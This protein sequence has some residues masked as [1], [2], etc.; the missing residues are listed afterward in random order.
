[1]CIDLKE[2]SDKNWCSFYLQS[3]TQA[4]TL[5]TALEYPL[6]GIDYYILYQWLTAVKTEFQNTT[7]AFR[8]LRMSI[9]APLKNS[10]ILSSTLHRY[11]VYERMMYLQELYYQLREEKAKKNKQ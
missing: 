9:K 6:T 8:M 3:D 5:P 11:I 1:M 2:A 4:L 10:Q 7:L